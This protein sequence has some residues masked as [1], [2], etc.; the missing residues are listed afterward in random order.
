M[1]EH[2]EFTLKDSMVDVKVLIKVTSH[3]RM[4]N[5]TIGDEQVT[6]AKTKIRRTFGMLSE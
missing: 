1:E 2:N 6:M 5:T 3:H 4:T